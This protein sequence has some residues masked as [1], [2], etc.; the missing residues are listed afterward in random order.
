M[1]LCVELFIAVRVHDS[2][3]RPYLGETLAVALVYLALRAATR[4]GVISAAASAFGIAVVIEFGQL[5]GILGILGLE[6]S[7]VA[8]T[9]LGTGYDPHDFIAYAAGA[10]AAVALELCRNRNEV[11]GRRGGPRPG[12]ADR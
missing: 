10:L 9:V 1:V 5:I 2:F 4:L 8:R 12:A 6:G 3:V 7:A 11:I